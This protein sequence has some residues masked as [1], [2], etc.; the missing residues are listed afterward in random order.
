MITQEILRSTHCRIQDLKQVREESWLAWHVLNDKE[1]RNKDEGREMQRLSGL[2]TATTYEIQGL[3][4]SF[5]EMST[6]FI[7]QVIGG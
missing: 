3:Q 5:K 6:E 7:Q 1:K 4:I 2:I